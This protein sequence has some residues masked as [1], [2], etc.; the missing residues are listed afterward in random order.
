MRERHQYVW[1]G[2]LGL[3]LRCV[4]QCTVGSGLGLQCAAAGLGLRHL[5]RKDSSGIHEL[6]SHIDIRAVGAFRVQGAES[7]VICPYM[8]I[9]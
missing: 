4:L 6:T 2:A 9:I 3:G 7:R 5:H 8:V 1:R